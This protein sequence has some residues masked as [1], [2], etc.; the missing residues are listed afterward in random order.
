M[1]IEILI[2][3]NQISNLQ[4]DIKRQEHEAI[5]IKKRINKK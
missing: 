3:K 5:G 2:L 1:I 4:N